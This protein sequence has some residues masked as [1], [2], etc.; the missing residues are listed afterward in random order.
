M[1]KKTSEVKTV[2]RV[3]AYV[4]VSTEKQ[5]TEGNSLEAQQARLTSYAAAFGYEIMSVEVDANESAGTL[6]RPGL[7][8]ALARL[9]ADECEGLLVAKLD[10][11]TRNVGDLC[12][13][14]SAYF[15][16]GG[17]SLL[18][19]GEQIDTQS[20]AGRM[21]LNMLT[22]IGQWEREAIG[23]RTS[24]VMQHMK[25]QGMF[26]GGWPPFGYRVDEEGNLVEQPFE[27]E[28]IALAGAMRREGIS[29]RA[30][31]AALGPNPRTGKAFG[32]TQIVRML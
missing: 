14:V 11:L 19:V 4:R 20:A 1:K 27:Q 18:S 32:V 21:M 3:V 10:R 8:R 30:V 12:H 9:D 5:A 24:A 29:L 2:R 6:E 26:T 15:R 28:K 23:E 17:H 31:A 22:V 16:D 13:L 25:S 7:K